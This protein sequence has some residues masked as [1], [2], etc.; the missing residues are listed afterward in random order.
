MIGHFV[1]LIGKLKGLQELMLMPY[2]VVRPLNLY[3]VFSI[4]PSF[5]LILLEGIM[6]SVRLMFAMPKIFSYICL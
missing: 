5:F 6:S 3:V 1:G 4:S 2:A